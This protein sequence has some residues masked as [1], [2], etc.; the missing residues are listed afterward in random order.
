MFSLDKQACKLV[1]VNPRSEKN[2]KDNTLASD[3]KFEITAG[4]DFL[5]K[6]H[7]DLQ[8]CLYTSHVKD[9]HPGHYPNLRLPFM[10]AVPWN[11]EYAGYE[12]RVDHGIDEDDPIVVTGCVINNFK[13][14]AQEG[15]TVVVDVRV[16]CHP[17]GDV[18]GMLCE[19]IQSEVQISLVPPSSGF[20]LD[21]PPADAKQTPGQAAEAQFES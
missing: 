13:I 18:L 2:G 19:L 6:L 12:L 9:P 16:Q 17:G 21:A 1:D 5:H 10:G 15:G 11:K 20:Q 8:V 3:L 4:N 14:E 7:P